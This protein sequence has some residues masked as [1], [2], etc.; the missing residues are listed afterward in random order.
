MRDKK[1]NKKKGFN[2]N[3]FEIIG[4]STEN[5]NKGAE[6][7]LIEATDKTESHIVTVKNKME[8]GDIIRAN[9]KINNKG[10]K[11]FKELLLIK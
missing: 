10:Y 1:Q 3:T 11:E 6:W 5:N 7:V 2:M 8:L 4:R 9:F